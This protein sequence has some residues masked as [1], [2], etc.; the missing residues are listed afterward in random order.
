MRTLT[1]FLA[2]LFLAIL[3]FFIF[4]FV[5]IFEAILIFLASFSIDIDYLLYYFYRKRSFS[6]SKT[7]R[8]AKENGHKYKKL[9]YEEKKKYFRAFRLFH[10]IETLIILFLLGILLHNLFYYV[11]IGALLH[12]IMDYIHEVKGIILSLKN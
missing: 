8:F 4:P 5:G 9:S 2:G 12:L 3:L 7:Y 1:H 6:L 11:L 10:G